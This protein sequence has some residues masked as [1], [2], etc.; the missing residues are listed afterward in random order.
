MT[1]FLVTANEVK[2]SMDC[3]GADA[4]RNDKVKKLAMTR[5]IATELTLLAMTR[6]KVPRNDR[7]K[8]ACNDDIKKVGFCPTVII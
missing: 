6:E 4:P 5:W 1:L 3:H 8:R 7:I 2:Q